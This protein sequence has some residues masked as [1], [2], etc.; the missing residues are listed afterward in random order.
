MSL[1]RSR[2]GAGVGYHDT[3]MRALVGRR[4]AQDF[5]GEETPEILQHP[6]GAQ[7]G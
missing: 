4:R 5:G 3:L 2:G 7:V 6:M 1:G